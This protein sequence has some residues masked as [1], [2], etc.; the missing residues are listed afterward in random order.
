MAPRRTFDLAAGDTLYIP[1]GFVHEAH[2]TEET[3]LHVTLGVIAYTWADLMVEAVSLLAETDPA[4]RRALPRDVLH[5][6]EGEAGRQMA[7]HDALQRLAGSDAMARAW[8]KIDAHFVLSRPPILDGQLAQ[9]AALPRIAADTVVTPRPT[10]VFD[11]VR[12]GESVVL[13]YNKA[14]VAFPS[15]VEDALRFAVTTPRYRAGDIPGNLDQEGQLVLVRRLVREGL[16][17]VQ[18]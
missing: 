11:I 9:L 10:A 15:H 2:A 1:R 17:T 5:G 8:E 4:L 3:S 16:L 13:L 12:D 18:E 14:R 7:F 6:E